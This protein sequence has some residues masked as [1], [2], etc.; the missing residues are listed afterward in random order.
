MIFD[1]NSKSY[2]DRLKNGPDK[3]EDLASRRVIKSL[4][5]NT[6][7]LISRKKI[8]QLPI[9]N[10]MQNDLYHLHLE[11]QK[12]KRLRDIPKFIE[13]S[14]ELYGDNNPAIQMID[15][16]DRPYCTLEDI[17][18]LNKIIASFDYPQ[19]VLKD[20]SVSDVRN[21]KIDNVHLI[22]HLYRND[23]LSLF[24]LEG[25]AD[26][27]CGI[28]A[29]RNT[30]SQN[31][32][33]ILDHSNVV[34]IV[35]EGSGPGFKDVVDRINSMSVDMILSRSETTCPALIYFRGKSE[36]LSEELIDDAIQVAMD[37]KMDHTDHEEGYHRCLDVLTLALHNPNMSHSIKESIHELRCIGDRYS[38]LHI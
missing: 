8:D 37:M 4:T 20:Q 24:N 32:I 29:L 16:L 17:E 19:I 35:N 2:H 6:D 33:S 31:S 12:L 25:I 23:L 7:K 11:I 15:I 26:K 21:D 18:R 34:M 10:K 36:L 38:S 30:I 9:P 14:E 28:H 27:L 1:N 3:L 13:L 5:N 22:W